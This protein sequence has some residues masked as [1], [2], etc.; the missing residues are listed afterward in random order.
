MTEA[1]CLPTETAPA[2]GTMST[3]TTDEQGIFHWRLYLILAPDPSPTATGASQS[4]LFDMIPTN[5]PT[6]TLL[7]ASN[8]PQTSGARVKIELPLETAGAP[9]VSRL[10]DPFV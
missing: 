10:V 2:S 7:V 8:P 3:L 4:V 5:P 9:T 1:C 6:G